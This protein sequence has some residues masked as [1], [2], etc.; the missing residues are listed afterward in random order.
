M[1]MTRKSAYL[2]LAVAAV[3]LL[4]A[5]ACSTT[6]KTSKGEGYQHAGA[7]TE[8]H[9]NTVEG[10]FAALA[11]SYTDWNS[12]S[13]PLKVQ[14]NQPKRLN[15]SA[16]AKMVHGKAL[17][18]SLRVFG[19]EVGSLYADNDSVIVVAKFNNM[20]CKESMSYITRTYGLT[21]ADIQAVLLGQVFTPGNGRLDAKDIKQ[22]KVVLGESS[23]SLTPK[24][25]PKGLSW[26]FAA[27][28][29]STAAP[30]LRTLTV[31]A[32]GHEPVVAA[33]GTAK[34]S[35]AGMA[36]PWVNLNTTLKGRKIDATLT[37]DLDKAKWDAGIE[38]GKPR[39]PSGARLIPVSKVLEI[40]KK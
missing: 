7:P 9:R 14:I 28:L 10:E 26:T 12:V 31:N 30:S 35:G 20:Y 6:K 38:I 25:L 29:S 23:I 33:Y 37:W 34:S 8:E 1:I 4:L 16:T 40:L 32:D 13:M 21:L 36:A 22:Y 17:A 39:I 18:V 15:V 5:T 3:G 11:Q 2:L 27:A 24:K 19:I